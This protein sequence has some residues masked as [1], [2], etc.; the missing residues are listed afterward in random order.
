VFIRKKWTGSSFVYYLV[1]NQRVE[2]KVKQRAILY[3]GPSPTLEQA[4]WKA[5]RDFYLTAIRRNELFD[6]DL[7]EIENQYQLQK[8]DIKLG[9]KMAIIYKLLIY[10]DT[11]VCDPA[12]PAQ[13]ASVQQGW[14]DWKRNYQGRD[15]AVAMTSIYRESSAAIE[16][17][18]KAMKAG[19]TALNR[20]RRE[21]MMDRLKAEAIAE[22]PEED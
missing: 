20:A 17:Q 10:T 13:D 11:P 1:Q 6:L 15:Y 8:I 4:L 18:Q 21:M 5:V 16:Q 7:T 9:V 14:A 3:L 22:G 12:D 19:T 2:G